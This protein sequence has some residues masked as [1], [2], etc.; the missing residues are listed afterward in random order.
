[1]TYPLKRV[2]AIAALVGL[3]CASRAAA[4]QGPCGVPVGPLQPDLIIDQ[5][6][7]ASQIFVSEEKFT[8]KSCSVVEG[9][10]TKPGTQVVLRFNSSSP[11]IGQADMYIGD[12]NQCPALFEFSDCH[13]HLHF[14]NY[15]AYRLWTVTG[16]LYWVAMR[17]ANAPADSG[18]N[19]Q[20]LDAATASGDLISGH[21]QGFCMVDSAPYLNGAGPAKYLSCSSNQ[22]ISIGWED[23]YPPQL[24][25]QFIQI[26]G[27]A[28]GDYVVENQVNP[29]QMLPESN[30]ANNFAAV[31]I[32]YTPRHGSIP[33][34]VAVIP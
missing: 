26:T 10:V 27:L 23:I 30:Y 15:T 18:I 5:G 2:L 11:N 32:H 19:A 17:D 1:M 25:D 14:K 24:P 31:K 7:L 28:E 20:L 12:P 29:T 22:G 3:I 9:V 21:K 33:A 4:Q 34:T 16:Y 6:L 8:S 13:Q